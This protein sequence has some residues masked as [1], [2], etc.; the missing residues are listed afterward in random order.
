MEEIIICKVIKLKNG[1]RIVVEEMPYMKSVAIV[2]GVGIGS[3]Y[4]DKKYQGISHFIEHMLFKGTK[5]RKD[6]LK[7][8]QVIEGIGGE[9]NASTSKETTHLYAKIPKEQFKIAFDVLADIILNSLIREE[10]LHKEKS[11]I[12]EEIRKYQDMP[13][14]LVEIL[15]DKV[16]WKEHPLGRSILGNEKSVTN[17][18]REDLL[19]HINEFYRP[20]NLVISV[21][22]NIKT[23][24]VVLQTK[25]YFEKIKEDKIKKNLFI[26]EKQ[27][28]F[29][30]GIKF[31]S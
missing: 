24:E 16:M 23:E 28:D 13:E 17:L 18:R 15:L 7:I 26:Y 9:I 14:E 12:I 27:K 25:K 11:V 10:D 4:E 8:S 20:N 29:Q 2:F 6:T 1:L 30:I 21:A 3:K 22:G 19:R 31:N 5:K